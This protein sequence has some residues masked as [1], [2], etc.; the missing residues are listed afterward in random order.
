M[1]NYDNIPESLQVLRDC[2]ISGYDPKIFDSKQWSEICNSLDYVAMKL[3]Y[4]EAFE[5]KKG[6]EMVLDVPY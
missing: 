1:T 2:I 5:S 6:Y 4:K 3:G